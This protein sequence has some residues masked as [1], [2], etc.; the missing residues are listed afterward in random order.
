MIV[1]LTHR[2]KKNAFSYRVD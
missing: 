1:S 2:E